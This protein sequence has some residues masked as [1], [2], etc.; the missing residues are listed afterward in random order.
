MI[1]AQGDG[2]REFKES[3]LRKVRSVQCPDHGQPPRVKFHG[4][5]LAEI[6]IRMSGCCARLIEL[7][8]RAIA[9]RLP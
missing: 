8:N 1:P 9:G 3:T 2:V 7:A 5:T 6:S 4:S